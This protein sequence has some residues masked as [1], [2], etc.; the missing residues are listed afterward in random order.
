MRCS[1]RIGVGQ[2]DRRWIPAGQDGAVAALC[3]DRQAVPAG[4]SDGR[5]TADGC[6]SFSIAGDAYDC[7]C[8]CICG[9]C[10]DA[11]PADVAPEP[12]PVSRNAA[13]IADA[14]GREPLAMN[15]SSFGVS[16]LPDEDFAELWDARLAE[17]DVAVR[18]SHDRLRCRG[19]RC[20]GVGYCVSTPS[21]VSLSMRLLASETQRL[22]SEPTVISFSDVKLPALYRLTTPLVMIESISLL[23]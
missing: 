13:A 15:R 16:F 14:I 23:V 9:S 6:K 1:A 22:P 8:G 10:D 21:G 19:L 11:S 7:N 17:P 5:C 20:V 2:R 3:N 18:A 12:Q 4:C